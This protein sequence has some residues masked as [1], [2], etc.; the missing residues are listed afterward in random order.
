MPLDS[1]PDILDD[2]R[3]GKMVIL[4]DDEDRENEG[5]LVIGARSDDWGLALLCTG[6]FVVGLATS[7][8]WWVFAIPLVSFIPSGLRALQSTRS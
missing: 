6:F 4:M 5:D 7:T 3:E 8:L 1:V 2:I